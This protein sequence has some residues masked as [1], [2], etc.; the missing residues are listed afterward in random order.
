VIGQNRSVRRR[1]NIKNAYQAHRAKSLHALS[2]KHLQRSWRSIRDLLGGKGCCVNHNS[3]RLI[4]TRTVEPSLYVILLII[5]D[6][7][8]RIFPFVSIHSTNLRRINISH[9]ALYCVIFCL[10]SA[11][12]ICNRY[13]NSLEKLDPNLDRT[14]AS[15]KNTQDGIWL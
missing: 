11:R 1:Q 10:L 4:G 6:E 7:V 12:Q 14:I 15:V 13:N 9:L 2:R 3:L 5:I 8:F